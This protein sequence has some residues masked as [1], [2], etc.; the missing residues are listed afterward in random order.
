MLG[1]AE[2]TAKTRAH[3]KELYEQH[4]R[5]IGENVNGYVSPERYRD[6]QHESLRAARRLSC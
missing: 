1:G 2:V 4:R 5:R 3:A 6:V